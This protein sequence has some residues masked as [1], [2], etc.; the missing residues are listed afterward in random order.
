MNGRKLADEALRARPELK[1]LFTTGFT[2][3]AVV[4]NGVLDPGVNFL[5]KPFTIDQLAARCARC[6][7]EP[8][9]LLRSAS[10]RFLEVVTAPPRPARRRRRASAAG[11]VIDRGGGMPGV[12]QCGADTAG[13]DRLPAPARSSS[14]RLRRRELSP[15]R[16]VTVRGCG[17][18]RCSRSASAVPRRRRPG[19]QACRDRLE[20]VDSRFW[21]ATAPRARRARSPHRGPPGSAV[22]QAFERQCAKSLV[23]ALLGDVEI[24][25]DEAAAFERLGADFEHGAVGRVGSRHAR[26]AARTS[27]MRRA[28]S[29]SVSP[30]P[31]RPSRVE[32]QVLESGR[33]SAKTS[34]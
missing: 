33:P 20:P 29:S 32:R 15:P 12:R 7:T 9:R 26:C 16:R 22:G 5:A 6:W 30:G 1:V 24:G 10:G 34:G 27:A 19:G 31:F 14:A 23:A 13:E 4:H 25:G 18:P 17:P 8:E 2:R 28:T 3:N 21:T 11:R